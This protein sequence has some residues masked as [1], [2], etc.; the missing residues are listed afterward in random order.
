LFKESQTSPSPP[1][2]TSFH[3]QLQNYHWTLIIIGMF[4][5]LLLFIAVS[6]SCFAISQTRRK[7]FAKKGIKHIRR[8]IS[9]DSKEPLICDEVILNDGTKLKLE[10][11]K[12]AEV[13]LF[14]NSFSILNNLE[15]C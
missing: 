13:N 14:F 15:N 10:E 9:K 11:L 2:Q 4:L 6:I 7:K 5:L 12:I 1:F 3:Q 8:P